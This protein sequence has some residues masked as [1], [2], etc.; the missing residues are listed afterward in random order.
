MGRLR[1]SSHWLI[2]VESIKVLLPF[3]LL[4]SLLFY[5]AWQFVEPAPPKH[6]TLASGGSG[7]AYE[8][9]GQRLAQHLAHSGF[10]LEVINTAGSVDNWQRLLAGEVD[11]AL[12][13]SGT[14]PEGADQQLE[15]VVSLALEPLLVFHRADLE[16][17]GAQDLL[18]ALAADTHLNVAMGP[19]GSGTERLVAT[20]LTEAGADAAPLLRMSS[21]DAAQR[22][23]AGEL[24]VA[25]FVMAVDAPLVHELLSDDSLRLMPFQRAEAMSRRLPYLSAV[26]LHQGVIDLQAN[27]P[28]SDI[29]LVAPVT[30]LV[31]RKD[32]HRALIQLLM[33]AVRADTPQTTLLGAR[34]QFPSLA[35]MDLPAAT[36]AIYLFERGPGF[37]QRH[38]PF[39]LASLVDRLAILI[40]PLLAI[41]LPLARIAPPALRWRI[42]RRIYRGYARLRLIDDDLGRVDAPLELLRSDLQQV[43]AFEDQ[44]AQ[45][46]VPLSYM[47]EFY[48]LRLH[49]AY[50]RAR[51]E[52]RISQLERQG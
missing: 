10:T 3:A 44:V 50:I 25:A 20:L 2:G 6:F 9:T 28:S 46:E 29:P 43:R 30:Y 8:Q 5:I 27:L 12:V 14:L 16:L 47:E 35:Y 15:A 37:L 42:R 49:V 48:N 7:G 17:Q 38:L 41:A 36:D 31:V 23:R 11:A 52:E 40:I 1:A 19:T 32:S 34:D 45:T 24:D 18:Q 4:G 22:L 39:W 13:Q 21:Q 51:L 26:T 33:E